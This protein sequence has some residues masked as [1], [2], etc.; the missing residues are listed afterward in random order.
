MNDNKKYDNSGI[1]FVNNR[2]EA[3]THSDF[4]GSITVEGVEY[5]LNI[6]SKNGAKG[7]YWTCTVKRKGAQAKPSENK[8]YTSGTSSMSQGH[9]KQSDGGFDAGDEIPF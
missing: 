5:F 3:A 7:E 1:F 2:K 4:Q 8:V 6:W 9:S